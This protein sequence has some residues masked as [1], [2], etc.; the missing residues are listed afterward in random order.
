MFVLAGSCLV[1]AIPGLSTAATFAVG[2]FAAATFAAD[3]PAPGTEAPA[4][5]PATDA[6]AATA[7]ASGLPAADEILTKLRTTLEELQSLKCEMR[8]TSLIAGMKLSAVGQYADQ[9][10]FSPIWFSP[11]K[12]KSF[13][14]R[15]LEVF[16]FF[17]HLHEQ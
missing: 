1:S 12:L 15:P 11:S 9:R 4:A 2:P 16:L 14:T 10:E 6:P 5:T 8:Q 7:D 17:Q 13:R 3:E